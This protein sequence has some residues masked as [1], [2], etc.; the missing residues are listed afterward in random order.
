M[1]SN[2]KLQKLC[3]YA[4]RMPLALDDQP[5]FAEHIEAWTYGPAIPKLYRRF[6][7]YGWQAIDPTDIITDPVRDSHVDHKARL[8]DV[9][10]RYGHFTGTQLEHL[11]TAS[12]LGSTPE[13]TR[14]R[15]R[16]ALRKSRTIP[17]AHSIDGR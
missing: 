9:W 15:V 14:L 1:I 16:T 13:A 8:D 4:Q 2:L 7:K 10:K 11:H 17:C 3:Y 6:K 5:L 12:V